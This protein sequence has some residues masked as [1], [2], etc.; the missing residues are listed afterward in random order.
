MPGLNI[1]ELAMLM[2]TYVSLSLFDL[3][4]LIH[5]DDLP[6]EVRFWKELR[7]PELEIPWK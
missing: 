1:Y 6:N 7:L 5:N 3:T 4:L 2:H